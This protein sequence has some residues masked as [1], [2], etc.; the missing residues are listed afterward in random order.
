VFSDVEP[1]D[2][3]ESTGM[4]H[5]Y[6]C[7]SFGALL[8]DAKRRDQALVLIVDDSWE[9]REATARCESMTKLKVPSV[10]CVETPATSRTNH[11]IISFAVFLDYRAK[12]MH[13]PVTDAMAPN[14][15]TAPT[16][17]LPDS[18]SGPRVVIDC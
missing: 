12:R 14:A 5:H 6:D 10:V 18:A 13:A 16:A 7:A 9:A 8:D 3:R 2:G 15:P 11:E 17:P 4:P 1:R